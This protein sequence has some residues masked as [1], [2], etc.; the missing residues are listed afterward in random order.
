MDDRFDFAVSLIERAG[1]LALSY[2][3]DL[4]S[5]DVTAKGPQDLVSQADR[6]T[7]ALIKS[8]IAERFPEDTFVG[9]E[10]GTS[11]GT[12]G[13]TWVVDPIDGTTPF[14]LGMTTWCVSIA[15][16]QDDSLQF[17]LILV[18]TT[19]DLYSARRGGGAT[20][21][22]RPIHVSAATTLA[23]GT[24]GIGASNKTTADE[25]A[26]MLTGLINAGG[27][28][29]RM[30]S[31]ALTLCYVAAGQLVGYVEPLINAWDCL[32]ALCIIEEAGGRTSPFLQEFGVAGTGPLVAGAP[33]A[34]EALTALLP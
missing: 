33:G 6:D 34:F 12:S 31:G 16:V 23:E 22:G 18:P 29:H 26:F 4:G 27:M 17:G 15:Y 11:A 25:L 30:G 24:T 3:N 13:G 32:A 7:E 1:D 21:N 5:L 8:A 20:L 14:L 10:T 9:E 28:F 19:G 2:F